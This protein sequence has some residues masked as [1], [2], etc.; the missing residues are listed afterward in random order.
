LKKRK[1]PPPKK[2]KIPKS[3]G[4]RGKRKRHLL[5]WTAGQRTAQ[6]TTKGEGKL[7]PK[8]KK[9]IQ[10]LGSSANCSREGG[11]SEKEVQWGKSRI[12]GKN[13]R[14]SQGQ[15]VC[16]EGNWGGRQVIKGKSEGEGGESFHRRKCQ[17]TWLGGLEKIRGLDKKKEGWSRKT[18]GEWG[19][20]ERC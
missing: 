5:G 6:R 10:T 13:R 7:P 3:Q 20:G 1:K 4:Y 2:K 18:A 16:P 17:L 11:G 14:R 15:T 8:M 19:R 12:R 9:G